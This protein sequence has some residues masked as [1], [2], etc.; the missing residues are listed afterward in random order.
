[1]AHKRDKEEDKEETEIEID[2][3]R[4]DKETNTMPESRSV[5]H[6]DAA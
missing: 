6:A 2:P 3:C 4:G 1:M 5:G